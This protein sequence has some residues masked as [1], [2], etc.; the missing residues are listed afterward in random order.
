MKFAV[1]LMVMLGLVAMTVLSVQAADLLV[2]GDITVPTLNWGDQQAAVEITNPSGYVRYVVAETEVQFVGEGLN[3]NRRVRSVGVIF[4]EESRTLTPRIAIPGN[5]GSLT[6]TVRLFDVVDTLD[7]VLPNMLFFDTTLKLNF[8]APESVQPYLEHQISMPPRVNVHPNFDND[9]S[10][11]FPLFLSQGM[12]VDRVEEITGG[13]SAYISEVIDGFERKRYLKRTEGGGIELT[14]PFISINEAT[15]EAAIA[16]RLVD[17]LV[18]MYTVTLPR[19]TAMRDSMAAAGAISSDTVDFLNA[20]TPLFKPYPLIG[21][22][23]LWSSLGRAFVT[24]A[25]PLHVF[26]ATDFCNAYIPFYMYAVQGPDSLNGHHFYGIDVKSYPQY[27]WGDRLPILECDPEYIRKGMMGQRVNWRFADEFAPTVYVTDSAL[28]NAALKYL[29]K[30]T[31]SLLDR[32]YYELLDTAGAYGHPTVS[33]GHR[34]W[35]WNLVATETLER[36]VASGVVN[37]EGNGQY[38]FDQSSRF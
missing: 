14:F 9:F 12:T 19:M 32:T 36:L 18:A 10:R 28:I 22:F 11:L 31:D 27:Y 17:S 24:R 33:F 3:P 4:P 20:A 15:A 21:M 30:D 38:R 8:A 25:A 26:D 35:F 6:A 37:R 16:S 13:D 7:N 34:Y 23:S 29:E 1:R 2:V 5:Y